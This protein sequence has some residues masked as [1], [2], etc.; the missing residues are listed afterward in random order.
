MKS[1]TFTIEAHD[2]EF[3]LCTTDNVAVIRIAR[4]VSEAAAQS[5]IDILNLIK[6]SAREVGRMGL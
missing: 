1:L 2:D 6:M 3:W 5:F 4:F